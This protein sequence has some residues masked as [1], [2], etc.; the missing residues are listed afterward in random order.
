MDEG[1]HGDLKST[2]T[3]STGL[4]WVSFATGKNPGKHGCYDFNIPKNY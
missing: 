2:I 4:A 3:P 1:V